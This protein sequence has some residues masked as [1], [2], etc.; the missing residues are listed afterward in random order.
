MKEEGNVLDRSDRQ[1][2]AP[3]RGGGRVISAADLARDLIVVAC[4]ISAG[5]HGALA[6]EHFDEGTGAGLGFLASAVLLAGLAVAMT[7]RP[8]S[9]TAF[10]V[11]AIVLAGLLASYALAITTGV[12]LLH[13]AAE[14]VDG[15]ALATKA[16]EAIGLLAAV[17]L[18]WRGRPAVAVAHPRTKGKL[19]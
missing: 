10:A 18:L 8:G 14:P 11:A 4:A 5:I 19:T 7:R 12:P 9:T 6:P 2:A 16:I 13:P 3:A 17:H 1:L 15:L